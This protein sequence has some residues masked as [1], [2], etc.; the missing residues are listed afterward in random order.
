MK[1]QKYATKAISSIITQ[2]VMK[3]DVPGY[4]IGVIES[5]IPTDEEIAKMSTK[6]TRMWITTNNKRMKAICK[7]MNEQ[8]L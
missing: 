4:T 6:E 1:K 5:F 3:T 8:N 2:I 7:L